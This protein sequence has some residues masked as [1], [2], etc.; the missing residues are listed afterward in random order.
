M[1]ILSSFGPN[2]FHWFR[3]SHTNLTSYIFGALNVTIMDQHELVYNA[4][5]D[6]I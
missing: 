5:F 1:K 4:R 3:Q 6:W 2:Y